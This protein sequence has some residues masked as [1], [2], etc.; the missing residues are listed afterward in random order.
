[1]L[2]N[3]PAFLFFF[4]PLAV[5]GFF[6]IGARL[7][8][9]AAAWLV[10]ASLVFYAWW[11]PVYLGLLIAL[12][13][14]NFAIGRALSRRTARPRGAAAL[15]AGGITVNLLLL[16]YF[17]YASFVLGELDLLTGGGWSLGTVVLPL[18]ISFYTF[19]Q[20]AYLVDA[21]RGEAR[22]Y[23]PV[24]YALF[25][26]YFPHLV[27]G[28]I[29]HHREMMP[30]FAD[31]RIYRAD[32]DN[33]SVGASILVIG[34]FKKVVLADGIAPYANLGFSAAAVGHAVTWVEAWGAA[35]AY[36]LQLYFDFSGYS[37]MAIGISRLFGIQLP[38][39]FH[40]PYRAT[41]IAE[42]WRRWHIT[43]S[44]FLR[45]YLY[46]PLGGN[47]RGPTRRYFNLMLTMLLGGFWHGAG[48]T[49]IVWGALHGGFLVVN[50]IWR[51]VAGRAQP[52]AALRAHRFWPLAAWLLTFLSVVIAW[53]FF[54]ADSLPTALIVLS[55]MAG[56]NGV[57]MPPPVFEAFGALGGWLRWI[58]VQP[59]ETS[60]GF[61]GYPQLSWI[62]G[63]LAI[64]LFCP[65]TQQLMAEY[66]PGLGVP[67]AIRQSRWPI[68]WRPTV[69]WAL[70]IAVLAFA[71]M[72][73][74]NRVSDFLYWQF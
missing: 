60:A 29:L 32:A 64:A 51:A 71:S 57:V 10:A 54:R 16:G 7:P 25:V 2:F 5:A 9:V 44:R 53:V 22:E 66:N 61:G 52:L 4:L 48:W 31:L 62:A 37:D 28:P 14:F 1:M 11:S 65:N 55:G 15:L 67:A 19:T 33:F 21:W 8:A 30:Q 59:G 43:L 46:V 63:L 35:L 3:S 50:H 73:H 47:R 72:L 34:L 68:R 36:T 17:K 6:L 42:F 13:A 26:T 41:S 49:F 40:S 39:N 58:G 70:F 18:G 23:N 38:I 45:D 12:I 20:V 74:L 69:T 27:A 24:H 56:L